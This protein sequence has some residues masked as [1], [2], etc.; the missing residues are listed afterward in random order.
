LEQRARKQLMV[1]SAAPGVDALMLNHGAFHTIEG[2]MKGSMTSGSTN[3]GASVLNGM[4]E[5]HS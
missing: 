5:I 2:K 3:S 1:L 4:M